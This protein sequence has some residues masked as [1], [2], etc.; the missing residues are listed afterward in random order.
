MEASTRHQKN[1]FSTTGKKPFLLLALALPCLLAFALVAGCASQSSSAKSSDASSESSAEQES[2][3]EFEPPTDKE[4]EQFDAWADD[5]VRNALA[6]LADEGVIESFDRDAFLLRDAFQYKGSSDGYVIVFSDEAAGKEL[7]GSYKLPEGKVIVGNFDYYDGVACVAYADGNWGSKDKRT[8]FRPES[9]FGYFDQYQMSDAFTDVPV[10]TFANRIDECDYLVLF[11][12]VL[13]HVDEDYYNNV[14]DRKV[15]TTFVL[16]IDVKQGKVVH[17]ENVGTDAPGP[18]VKL[19][20][21]SGKVLYDD[22]A[23]YLNDLLLD[24]ADG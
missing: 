16:V 1:P 11:D 17:I 15:V 8:L 13:T 6:K 20:E 21:A 7:S 24:R 3:Y 22:L 9:L 5:T 23:A 4:V 12:G 14:Y 18:R 2:A 19:D 10:T